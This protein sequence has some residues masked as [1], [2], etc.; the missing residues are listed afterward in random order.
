MAASNAQQINAG[1]NNDFEL[2][3][4]VWSGEILAKF[5]SMTKLLGLHDVKTLEPGAD[6]EMFP[7][8]GD[9]DAVYHAL[10]DNIITDANGSD[11]YLQT[12]AQGERVIYADR[13]CLSPILLNKVEERIAKP[14]W[15]GSY[16]PKLAYAL[17]KLVDQNCM[18]VLWN[19][20]STASGA[21]YTGSPAGYTDNNAMATGADI[22]AA[23]LATQEVFD[24][25]DVPE[26]DRYVLMRPAEYYKFV[27]SQDGKDHIDKDYQP[28][29]VNGQLSESLIMRACGFQIIKTNLMPT[30]TNPKA[31]TN[32]LLADTKG[33]D[34]NVDMT[35]SK[36]IMF[37]REAMGTC[38]SMDISLSSDWM[39]EY[40]SDL[41]VASYVMG[42]GGLRPECVAAWSV[43][44]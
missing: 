40:R 42:H 16:T 43:T 39:A 10:G 11:D 24:T 15:R 37:Q 7:A 30:G 33:N 38:K 44:P 28:M 14:N 41:V 9:V 18:R 3:L 13:E 2:S 17:A 29:Q 32:Q 21:I 36:L 25:K 34:Y 6:S 23:L 4:K 12:V 27:N 8:H 31:K 19:L 22:Y 26:Y 35:G 5:N 1:L 20:A